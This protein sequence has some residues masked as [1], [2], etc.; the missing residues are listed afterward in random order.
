RLKAQLVEPS[1]ALKQRILR[2]VVERIVVTDEEILIQHI[3]PGDDTSR[4][5]LR[6][7]R[8]ALAPGASHDTLFP[9]L[10]ALATDQQRMLPATSEEIVVLRVALRE[11][12]V[13]GH[14][15]PG[16]VC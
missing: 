14:G 15:T 16:K 12:L 9:V 13:L 1:F 2:L 5:Y 4:L 7:S 11:A 6:P 3:I 8:T 10:C